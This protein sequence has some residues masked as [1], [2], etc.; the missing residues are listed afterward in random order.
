[1]SAKKQDSKVQGRGAAL[2]HLDQEGRASMVDVGRKPD[3][4]REAVA[5]GSV[6]MEKQTLELI[7]KGEMEKG[8][9]LSVAR[10]AGIMGAKQTPHLIPLCHPIPLSYVGVELEVDSLGRT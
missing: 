8:D 1:M 3:T 7:K 5:R 4:E 9:V 10:I 2:T 6:V